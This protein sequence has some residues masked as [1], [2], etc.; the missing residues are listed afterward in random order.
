MIFTEILLFLCINFICTLLYIV[1]YC[2]KSICYYKKL[3]TILFSGEFNRSD[4]H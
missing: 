2:Y 3:F 4:L 1:N